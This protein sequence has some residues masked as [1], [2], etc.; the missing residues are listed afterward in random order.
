MGC[1]GVK[2]IDS[3][4]ALRRAPG[5]KISAQLKVVSTIITSSLS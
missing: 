1:E 4:K 3:H 5:R 2:Y